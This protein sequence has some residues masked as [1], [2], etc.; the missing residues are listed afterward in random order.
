MDIQGTLSSA[1]NSFTKVASDGWE[2][3]KSG[4]SYAYEQGKLGC[5]HVVSKV[6]ENPRNAA[7]AGAATLASAVGVAY[8]SGAFSSD[9]SASAGGNTTSV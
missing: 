8:I 3:A 4:S 5:D 7:I 1:W 9:A 2:S 6:R